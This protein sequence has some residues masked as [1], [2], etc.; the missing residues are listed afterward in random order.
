MIQLISRDDLNKGNQDETGSNEIRQEQKFSTVSQP[1][2]PGANDHQK[3]NETEE[4]SIP[5][6]ALLVDATVSEQQIEYPID[7]KL[8]NESFNK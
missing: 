7:L 1:M 4:T 8:I 6:G 5:S 3:E 2:P